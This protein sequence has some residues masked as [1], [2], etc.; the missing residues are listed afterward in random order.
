M[1]C[2]PTLKVDGTYVRRYK[3]DGTIYFINEQASTNI[4][5]AGFHLFLSRR[6]SGNWI[7]AETMKGYDC[8]HD[9]CTSVETDCL[10]PLDAR[11]W[12]GFHDDALNPR[13]K[14]FPVHPLSELAEGA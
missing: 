11:N 9:D 8:L 6:D 13:N 12:R 14:L 5:S 4:I 3:D 7:V 1:T 10:H 2:T